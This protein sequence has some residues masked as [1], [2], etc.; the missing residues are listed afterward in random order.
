M[1]SAA[2]RTISSMDSMTRNDEI[3]TLATISPLI[4]PIAMQISSP[5]S[6]AGPITISPFWTRSITATGPSANTAPT[7]RSNSPAVS[8][9]VMPSA[10]MPSSGMYAIMLEMLSGDR[11]WLLAN[12]KPATTATKINSDAICGERTMLGHGVVLWRRSFRNNFRHCRH[13]PFRCLGR[14]R[15]LASRRPPGEPAAHPRLLVVDL[16]DRVDVGL[17]VKAEGVDIVADRLARGGQ[18]EQRHGHE[19][20]RGRKLPGSGIDIS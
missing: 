1:Y 9:K 3:P 19:A 6:K 12:P 14:F 16:Q 10:M 20:L 7:E 17:V 11:K 13:H 8:S 15:C 5:I 2:P 18:V 4:A